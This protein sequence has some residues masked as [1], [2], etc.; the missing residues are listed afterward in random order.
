M[1]NFLTLFRFE[2]KELLAINRGKRK[3]DF[4]GTLVSLAIS[5]L[6]LFVLGIFAYAILESYIEVRFDKVYDTLGRTHEFLNLIYTIL[7]VALA[8]LSLLRMRRVLS[9]FPGKELFLR[10]PVK[11]STVFLAK[12]S[13]L[14]LANYLVAFPVILT[15]NLV[16]YL[17]F[18]PPFVFWI[19]TA[20]VMVLLPL[21]AFI[22]AAL[23]LVPFLCIIR[24]ILKS[25][26]AVFLT[27]CGALTGAFILYAKL[28]SLIQQMFTLGSI[29]FLFNENFVSFMQT[30]TR[31]AFPANF[32][33]NLALGQRVGVSL[34]IVL[35]VVFLGAYAVYLTTHTLYRIALYKNKETFV[36]HRKKSK[37]RE[38]PP[39][40]ALV[41]KEF[42]LVYREPKYAFSFL[43]MALCMPI[44]VYSCFTLFRTLIENTLGV[45]VDFALSL[46]ITLIFCILTNTFCATNISREG[47]SGMKNKLFP[48]SPQ[49]ILLSKVVFCLIVSLLS[50]LMSVVLL[51]IMTDVNLFDA[52]FLFLF[53]GL[54]CLSHIL[55]STR[56]DLNN[57]RLDSDRTAV[58]NTENHTMAKT[59][60]TGLIFAFLIG[61]LS[62]SLLIF[63]TGGSTLLTV[64]AYVGPAIITLIYLS[65]ALFY[66]LFRLENSFYEMVE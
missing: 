50:L 44:M 31:V 45:N 33:A 46:F 56:M 11:S 2:V 29:R 5:F 1:K 32:L 4:L 9:D 66:Y 48:L 12:L 60:L 15:A 16:V 37:T 19:L 47:A 17:V 40:V 21:I 7:I 51:V 35:A 41:N 27:I 43:A 22:L 20:L 64:G 38:I 18:E 13:A 61:T 58:E 30:L 14:L 26:L 23:L 42:L 39:F 6:I 8:F 53:G 49:K 36:V 25:Y 57:A 52:L 10:L 28:L 54:F 63:A 34:L 65:V 3:F 59:T 62:V 24:L 55:I